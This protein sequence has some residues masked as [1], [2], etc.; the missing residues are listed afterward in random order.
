MTGDT[1][2]SA[3]RSTGKDTLGSMLLAAADRN[4]GAALRYK[5]GEDWRDVSYADVG[6]A[7]REIARGLIALGIEPG[8]RVAILS[9]TK[10]DWT[11]AD[12]GA[13]CAAAVVVPVY[14]TASGEEVRHVL[15]DSGARLV[16]CEDADQ[17]SKVREVWDDTDLEHAVLFEGGADGV[18]TLNDLRAKGED[19]D[20]D[21]VER[22]LEQVSP[23]DL[24]TI[25]YT[26]GTT[27]A[28]TG[29]E[30][31]HAN[32]RAD[33]DAMEE[34]VDLGDETTLFVFLPLAHALTRMAQML[35]L[36]VG[37]DARSLAGGQGQADR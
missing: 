20:P 24:F 4:D 19:A 3:K 32:Y 34:L 37:G 6:R 1:E 13:L 31:T 26:S 28:P 10:A 22:R 36:D 2:T 17:L 8:D 33:I 27:G 29:C 23:D 9:D 14:H 35:T 21:A 7:V 18:P 25:I 30:L 5:D 15:S 11:L 12:F 16:F